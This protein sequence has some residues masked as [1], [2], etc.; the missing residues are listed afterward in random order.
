[1]SHY[2]TGDE[3]ARA[4]ERTVGCRALGRDYYFTTN[5]GLFSYAA[6]DDASLALVTR[7]PALE[8]T[9]LDLG[10]GYGAIG[11]TLAKTYGVKLTMSDVNPRA[12]RYAALNAERNGVDADVVMSDCFETIKGSFDTIVVNPPI[13]AGKKVT[14]RMF[15]ESYEHLTRGGSFYAVIKKKHGALSAAAEFADIYDEMIVLHKKKGCFVYRC[16]KH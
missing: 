2:F 5:A 8:G 1:M 16:V 13:H 12:L 3:P 11:I 10:C 4:D 6:V 15:R 7:V 14:Y 9:L